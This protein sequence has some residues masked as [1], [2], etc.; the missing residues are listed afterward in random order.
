MAYTFQLIEGSETAIDLHLNDPGWTLLD[1]TLRL[2]DPEPIRTW[3]GRLQ[4][5]LVRE[6]EGK[7]IMPMNLALKGSTMD[8]LIDRANALRER[9]RHAARYRKDG[10]GD[11]V[12]LEVKPTSG[13]HTVRFPV[14]TGEIDMG[15]LY[16]RCNEPNTAVD[17][18]PVL[19]YCEPY[20]EDDSIYT[21]ENYV[22]NPGWWRWAAAPG[23]SWTE[24]NG[25]DV[26]STQ[27]TTYYEV[28]GYSLKQVYIVDAVNDTGVI[29]D[30]ITVTADTAYYFQVRNYRAAGCDTLTARVYDASNAAVIAASAL[31]FDG[32]AG[33]WDKQG[34]SFTTPAGCVSVQIELYCLAANSVAGGTAYWDAVYLEP[35]SDAPTGWS[36][37]RNLTNELDAADQINVLCVTEI[38]GEVEAEARLDLTLTNG[39]QY[40]HLAR[41]TQDSPHDFIWELF[42]ADAVVT[43]GDAACKDTTLVADA[44]APGGQR[45]RCTFA[46]TQTMDLRC[47]WDISTNLSSYYGKFAIAVL[48]RKTGV[49]DTVTMRIDTL[50]ENAYWRQSG[51]E[52]IDVPAATVW[53]LLTG[54]NIMSFPIGGHDNDSWGAGNYWRIRIW[55]ATDGTPT[56]E[57]YIA[58][59][60]LIP[61]NQDYL[62]SGGVSLA[63]GFLLSIKELDG[64]RGAFPY[65]S[66]SG[67][68][69]GGLGAVGTY[70]LLSPEI[71]NWLYLIMADSANEVTITDAATASITYR[72]RGI[73]L[74]G[75]DP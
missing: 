53:E 9:L 60:Y 58:G 11:E 40:F 52:T 38:P 18:I 48:A 62:V 45:V 49:S 47:Y 2:S 10:W 63:A 59:V 64:D 65:S 73:F 17:E 39:G 69:Y 37:G 44:A 41:R 20:W 46:G 28:M 12:F 55:A 31:T 29:S 68:Y 43:A 7:R 75:S 36:S 42:G 61:L 50:G 22:D 71:E 57:L 67:T 16:A 21:L 34:V 56:D 26:T 14:L 72:P 33:A 30:A 74:R 24:V 8:N 5:K 54:W 51:V 23:D 1:N 25:A 6:E 66:A 4:D 19:L 35:R 70:P 13:T 27:D 32:A 3:G 15:R